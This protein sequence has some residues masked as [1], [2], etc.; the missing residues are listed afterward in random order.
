[1]RCANIRNNDWVGRSGRSVVN[2]K[3]RHCLDL[4]AMI[5]VNRT[6]LSWKNFMFAA[7]TCM[8][9]GGIYLCVKDG[10]FSGGGLSTNGKVR[11]PPILLLL[12]GSVILF[13]AI[14]NWKKIN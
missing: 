10:P 8:L 1:M 3:P 5:H 4:T 2:F 11:S 7:G 6:L 14:K 12:L 13:F 9:I